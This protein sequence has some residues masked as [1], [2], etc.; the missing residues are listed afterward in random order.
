MD[1]ETKEIL[2]EA[3]HVKN[4]LESDGW[5]SIKAKL[6]ARILDLQNINNLDITQ[7]LEHQLLG[8][9]MAVSEI[10]NWL[11]D[12]VYGFVEQQESNNKKADKET[13]E[14]YISVES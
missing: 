11:K 12:D 1:K 3:D 10:W 4:M 14:A 5:K 2:S 13:T 6:D 7:S 9:K 8:R